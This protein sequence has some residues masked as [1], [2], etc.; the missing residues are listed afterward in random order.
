MTWLMLYIDH[1]AKFYEIFFDIPGLIF[2][3]LISFIILSVLYGILKF[4][5]ER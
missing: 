4:A 1:R 3:M 2:G 5:F